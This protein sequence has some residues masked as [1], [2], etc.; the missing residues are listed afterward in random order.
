MLSGSAS[1][2]PETA[3][4]DDKINPESPCHNS[5]PHT[6]GTT[7]HLNQLSQRGDKQRP[8]GVLCSKASFP[9]THPSQ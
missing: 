7:K 8:C 2:E 6:V 5:G 9:S 1:S 4:S 3:Q